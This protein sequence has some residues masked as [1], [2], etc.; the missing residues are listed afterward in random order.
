MTSCHSSCQQHHSFIQAPPYLSPSPNSQTTPCLHGGTGSHHMPHSLSSS[1]IITPEGIEHPPSPT[2]PPTNPLFLARFGKS[3]VICCTLFICVLLTPT[4]PSTQNRA[5]RKRGDL[6]SRWRAAAIA[7]LLKKVSALVFFMSHHS[8]S[9]VMVPCR[10]IPAPP[11]IYFR[12][13]T[14]REGYKADGNQ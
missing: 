5:P 4:P 6:Q 7:M 9:L 1:Q 3:V 2:L 13:P 8:I 11:S 10:L 14:K 12:A